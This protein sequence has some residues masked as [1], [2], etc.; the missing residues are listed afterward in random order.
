MVGTDTTPAVVTT[1]RFSS[2]V[3]KLAICSQPCLIWLG[4]YLLVSSSKHY[5]NTMIIHL[6]IV[7]SSHIS[8]EILNRISVLLLHNAYESCK[9]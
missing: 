4:F 2:T 5:K 3:S 7:Q 9:Q 1:H 8:T 6:Y